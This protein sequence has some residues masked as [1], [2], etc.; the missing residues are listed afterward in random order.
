MDKAEYDRVN[1]EAQKVVRTATKLMAEKI[2]AST[3]GQSGNSGPSGYAFTVRQNIQNKSP[4]PSAQRTP[5]ASPEEDKEDNEDSSD[6]DEEWEV[7]YLKSSAASATRTHAA[8]SPDGRTLH[9]PPP[10]LPPTPFPLSSTLTNT[11]VPKAA[12]LNAAAAPFTM[13]APDTVPTPPLPQKPA[14]TATQPHK[15]LQLQHSTGGKESKLFKPNGYMFLCS[16]STHPECVEKGLFGLPQRELDSMQRNIQVEGVDGTSPSLIYLFNFQTRQL[17]GVYVAT[18]PPA[19]NIDPEVSAQ[20][21][22]ASVFMG[23]EKWQ[24]TEP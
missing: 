1:A 10:P 22:P 9:P 19:L 6:D 24:S 20:P 14:S 11:P 5:P 4:T 7:G 16:N 21:T 17:H 12:A 23:E 8:G 15:L 3:A 18:A 13:P 2:A